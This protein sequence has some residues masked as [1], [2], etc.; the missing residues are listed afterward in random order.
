MIRRSLLAALLVSCALPATATNAPWPDR[1]IR[2]VVPFAA[3]G[4]TDS[5][6]RIT[7]RALQKAL[8]QPV[9]VENRTGGEGAVAAAYVK[10]APADGYTLLFATTSSLAASLVQ[11]DA[12]FDPVDDFA[13]IS[14][15]GG[16]PYAVFVNPKVPV[17]SVQ[18]LIAH[19]RAN[20]LTYGTIN[21]GEHLAATQFAKSAGIELVRAP[22]NAS[23][24]ADLAGGRIDLYIGPIGQGLADSKAGRVRLLATM[25]AE[26]TKATPTVPAL[27]EENIAVPAASLSHQMLLAPAKTPPDVV[28]RLAREVQVAIGTPAVRAE[29]EKLSLVPRATSPGQLA[30]EI[31]ETQKVWGQFVREAGLSR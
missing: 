25:T 11:R 1:P 13:P 10:K 27:G 3:G 12:G 9:T 23:P 6:A 26:R 31:A 8:Y 28:A 19:A 21:T 17:R 15:V 4:V 16:F 14:T 18:D 29:L 30:K 22:Y 7:A 20:K 24:V 2:I 5:A